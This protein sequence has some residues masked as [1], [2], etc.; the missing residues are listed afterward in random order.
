MNPKTQATARSDMDPTTPGKT[1]DIELSVELDASPEDVFRAVTDG[2]EIAKWL[3][4]EAR[5][6][7]P[8][9]GK[10]GTIWLSW[11][12]G[13]AVEKPI[14]I[15][16]APRRMLHA[17]GKN[18]ETKAP[19]WVDWLIE[20]KAGG[21]ATLRLVHSGF[22]TGADWDDEVESYA[23]GWRLMLANLRHY[24]ARHAKKPA[25]HVIF[26]AKSESPREDVWRAL[27]SKLAFQGT[28]KSGD[29]F[30]ITTAGPDALT[31]TIDLVNPARD[32]ALVVHELDDALLRFTLEG[33]GKSPG[34]TFVYGYVIA[35]GDGA[36]TGRARE[37]ASKMGTLVGQLG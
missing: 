3:A 16:D 9:D 15:W 29:A 2:T 4:P 31:G 34:P 32:L 25:V 10:K 14:E 23:R 8:S 12:E 11:G 20:A 33:G 27:L 1:R 28:P 22:S 24:F 30:R 36:S 35:F 6:T 21:K 19:L 37:L 7:P 26:T 13:M 17:S 18:S 5:V